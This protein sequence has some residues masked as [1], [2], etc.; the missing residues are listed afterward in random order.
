MEP[1]GDVLRRKK[2]AL[3]DMDG[4]LIDSIGVWN[5]TDRVLCRELTGREPDMSAL[6]A[7]R[8]QALRRFRGEDNPYIRYCALLAESY[9]TD[10][11]ARQ[12]YDRR[13]AIAQGL[14]ET[15]DYKPGADRF[16][17][18]L[19]DMGLRLIL[20]TTTRRRSV[21]TYRTRNGN[22]V[23]KAPLDRLFEDIYTGEDAKNIKPDPEIYHLIFR[24]TGL[25]AEQCVVFED[26]LAG[27][28]AAKAAGIETAAVYDRYSD[29]DR[30]AIDALADWP[31]ADYGALLAALGRE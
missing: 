26:S 5:E 6:Q 8:D 11:T 22:I 13:Y 20:V 3:F 18:A 23:N 15:L 27:V 4:T 31:T 25:T 24:K 29:A 30:A 9:G 10:M 17:W 14:L 19:K 28:Q 12:I 1:L 21:D 16:L 2:A 7:R